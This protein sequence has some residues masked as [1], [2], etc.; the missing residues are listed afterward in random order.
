ML[1]RASAFNVGHLQ[2]ARKFFNMCSLR[3]TFTLGILHPIKIIVVRIK[4]SIVV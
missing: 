1:Q 3:F 2:G 4:I